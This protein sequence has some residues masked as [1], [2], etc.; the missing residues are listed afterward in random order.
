MTRPIRILIGQAL[1]SRTASAAELVALNW[2]VFHATGSAAMVGTLT[3]ARLVPLL[4]A[5]P[6]L[7]ARADRREPTRLLAGVL[8]WGGTLTLASAALITL[9]KAATGPATA[10]TLWVLV[11]LTATRASATSAEPAIRN[12]V[13]ARL[14]EQSQ[15][16]H[17][18]SSLSLV[19]NFSLIL[20]PAMAAAL[21]HLGGVA[22]A[23]SSCGI[24][25]LLAA[26]LTMGLP[27]QPVAHPTA[28]PGRSRWLQAL[29]LLPAH[30]R[31]G[32]QL[33]LA[34]GPMLCIFPY[35]AMLPVLASA[36]YGSSAEVGIA[37]LSAAAGAGALLG[38]VGL[39][40]VLPQ[41]PVAIAAIAAAAVS[42]PMLAL[43]LAAA[44]P[45][46]ALV[47]VGALGLLGQLYRTANRAATL[48][49]A[50]EPQRGLISGVAHSDRVLIPLGALIFGVVADHGGVVAMAWAMA[51]SN[52]VLVAP[53]LAMILAAPRGE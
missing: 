2:W 35:T 16:L 29:R 42:L 18:M 45:W 1:L 19:V 40:Y 33:L 23:L 15:L 14:S 32:A 3:A 41:R 52:A 21:L 30:R 5:A 48:L 43:T 9:D 20:G 6:R 34:V 38:A 44:H 10:Q 12:T 27:R 17:T 53:A 28:A 47:S 36:V 25:Y 11:A 46:A 26:A 4:I 37:Y 39:R 51:L 22:L 31:L 24:G 13:L 49:L 50:P 7:G 8:V